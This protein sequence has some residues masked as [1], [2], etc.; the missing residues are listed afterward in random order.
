MDKLRNLNLS[1]K[2]SSAFKNLKKNKLL[3]VVII[4]VFVLIIMGILFGVYMYLL[5]KGDLDVTF[6]A[7][8]VDLKTQKLI[9]IS[10]DNLPTLTKPEFSLHTWFAVDKS[11]YNTQQT[12]KYAHLISYG[13]LRTSTQQTDTLSV[14]VWIEN[15]TNNLFIVYRTDDDDIANMNY[16][17][18]SEEFN[19]PNTV[20]VT[21]YL[22]NEWNLLSLVVKSNNLMVYMNGKLY[23]T[24]V[25]KGILFYTQNDPPLDIQIA[26]DRNINGMQKNIRFRENAYTPSEVNDL[27]FSGPTKLS[28]PDIRGIDYIGS[29]PSNLENKMLSYTGSRE[30]RFLNSGADLVND[31]LDGMGTFFKQF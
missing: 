1:N 17:P 9:N 25:N 13:N 24:K 5:E 4:L 14:G 3:L 26:T 22:L 21:N 8:G 2:M 23:K 20:L 7:E 16:N 19:C 30:R 6:H 12:K 10:A 11:Q 29:M 15:K 28:L 18:N 27:Y 31:A